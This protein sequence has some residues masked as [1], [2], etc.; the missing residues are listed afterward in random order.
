LS[1]G[2]SGT[3]SITKSTFERSPIAVVGVSKDLA[4]SACSCVILL[5]V[6]SLARS[7]S[8]KLLVPVQR[9]DFRWS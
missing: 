7:L 3:A 6:T 8:I 9:F 5:L 1:F 4:L 2:I